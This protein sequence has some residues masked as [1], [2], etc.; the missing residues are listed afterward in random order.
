MRAAVEPAFW[1][2]VGRMVIIFGLGL[3]ISLEVTVVR[4]THVAILTPGGD[5]YYVPL[6]AQ[7]MR[8]V[9]RVAAVFFIAIELHERFGAGFSWR[10][11]LAA[12]VAVTSALS[13]LLTA[14]NRLQGKVG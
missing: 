8:A 4:F 7:V 13:T 1:F 6:R 11:P 5:T 9:S 12:A 14:R 10:M 2:D 3:A